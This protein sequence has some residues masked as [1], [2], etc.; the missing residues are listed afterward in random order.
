MTDAYESKDPTDFQCPLCGTFYVHADGLLEHFLHFPYMSSD[1]KR[2][3]KSGFGICKALVLMSYNVSRLGMY[4]DVVTDSRSF[5]KIAYYSRKAH[6]S[7][8][9]S[10]I[11]R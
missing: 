11:I 8:Q 4:K 10:E 7:G 6:E 1:F 3:E 5:E 9:K 2:S